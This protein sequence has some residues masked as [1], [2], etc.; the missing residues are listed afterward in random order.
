MM[1]LKNGI[2]KSDKISIKMV[3]NMPVN[4]PNGHQI[5]KKS[6]NFKFFNAEK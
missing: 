2:Q 4:W 1:F 5:Y 6:K 3:E